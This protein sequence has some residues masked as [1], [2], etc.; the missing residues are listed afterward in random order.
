MIASYLA[1]ALL[2]E[3]EGSGLGQ[4][5]LPGALGAHQGLLSQEVKKLQDSECVVEAL[6]LHPGGHLQSKKRCG[7]L[8]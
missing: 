2:V 4:E 5:G 1:Q 6:G 8:Q 3:W 7:H